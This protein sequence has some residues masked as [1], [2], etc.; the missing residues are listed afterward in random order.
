MKANITATFL[1]LVATYL[2]P[3]Y[4]QNE[5]SAR[6]A[7][8][9][10]LTGTW[11]AVVTED[12]MWRMVTP[13]IGDFTNIP[14]NDAAR[15]LAMQWRPENDVGNE[16]IGYGAPA[17]MNEPAR[18]KISWEDD[19]TLKMEI[20][21][22][23]QTRRFHFD[24]NTDP[25]EPSRQGFTTASWDRGIERPTGGSLGTRGG[26]GNKGRTLIAQTSNL[27]PGY[28]RKNGI[29]FSNQTTVTEYIE[30]IS[31]ADGNDWLFDIIIVEDPVFLREPWVVS[32]NFKKENDDSMW[33]PQDCFVTQ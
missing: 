7:A 25:G 20:D 8:L 21:A 16:C 31:L 3:L 10:D 13:L 17:I 1:F 9:A 12:W 22:G 2:Q 29:P 11:V 32:R 4:A 27:I 5:P 18:L 14:A 28:L 15:E 23:M 26:Y 6:E 30:V 33:N 24:E 19:Q